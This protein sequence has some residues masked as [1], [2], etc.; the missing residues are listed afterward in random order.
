MA[1]AQQ[2][3]GSNVEKKIQY[4]GSKAR[5]TL[6]VKVAAGVTEDTKMTLRGTS[7]EGNHPGDLYFIPRIK[8]ERLWVSLKI[9]SL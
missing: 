1:L 5:K 2:Q 7:L 6:V 8:A 3:P 4:Q 9:L